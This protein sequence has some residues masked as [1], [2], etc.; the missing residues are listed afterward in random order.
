MKSLNLLITAMV[1]SVAV[2]AADVSLKD[3]VTAAAKK[4]AD[5]PNYS[6]KQSVENAG[7]NGGGGGGGGRGGGPVDGRIEKGGFAFLISTRGENKVESV[8][9]GTKGAIKLEGSWK[10]AAEAAGDGTGGGGG[11]GGGQ[12]P[13]RFFSR[14]VAN[15]KAPAEQAEYLVGQ[16]T[17]L[18]KADG[19]Y[20]GPLSKDGAKELLTM[21]PRG[22]GGEGPTVTEAKGSVTFWVKDGQLAKYAIKVQ[23]HV[24]FNNNDRDVDRTTT[25]EIKDVGTTKVEVPEEAAKKAS[26]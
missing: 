3:E 16:A 7:G 17:E 2:R 1:L 20:S 24:S 13:G 8:I 18:K 23:G 19:A 25:V 15:F 9:K 22:G 5:Q 11:G 21:G 10:S 12:N 26:L 6:W 4:L 14:T